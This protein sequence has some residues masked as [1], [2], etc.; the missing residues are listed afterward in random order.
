M[1]T[2]RTL[3]WDPPLDKSTARLS[4]TTLRPFSKLE[5][6]NYKALTNAENQTQTRDLRLGAWQWPLWTIF[7]HVISV[8]GWYLMVLHGSVWYSMVLADI[9]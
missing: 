6:N 9:V 8:I 1:V 4:E 3:S 2:G 5:S 7:I